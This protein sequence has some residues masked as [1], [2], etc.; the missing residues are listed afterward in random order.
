M[1]SNPILSAIHIQTQAVSLGERFFMVFMPILPEENC[2][3]A[4]D[5]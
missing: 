4:S 3:E 5:L 1:G 2:M